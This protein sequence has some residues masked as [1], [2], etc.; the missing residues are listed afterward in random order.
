MAASC[1]GG[2][3]ATLAMALASR[4]RNRG[5]G[6][7]RR[8]MRRWQSAFGSGVPRSLPVPGL[9]EQVLRASGG[10]RLGLARYRASRQFSLSVASEKRRAGG[11][12][13]G[14]STRAP[15]RK[16]RCAQ[17]FVTR[18]R[19]AN[20]HGFSDKSPEHGSRCKGSLQHQR[21]V[22]LRSAFVRLPRS[23]RGWRCPWVA[24]ASA[25]GRLPAVVLA[26]PLA[27]SCRPCWHVWPSGAARLR[28]HEGSGL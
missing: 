23:L 4:R 27:Q 13:S 18:K 3:A 22:R 9:G 20:A 28:S 2:S 6:L 16:R 24:L 21:A 25:S 7:A 5:P 10:W 19:G 11:Y 14:R 8:A 17:P 15:R 26:R 12:A 1:A